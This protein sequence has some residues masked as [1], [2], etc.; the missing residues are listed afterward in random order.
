MHWKSQFGMLLWCVL[1]LGLVSSGQT[2]N[3]STD[4]LGSHDFGSGRGGVQGGNANACIYCHAP[5]N[6]SSTI[7]LWNQTLSTNQYTLNTNPTTATSVNTAS[8]LCLSCHDGSVAVG[9]TLS[10]GKIT[11]T[12]TVESIGGTQLESSHPFSV[13]PELQDDP[14]VVATLI[15]THQTK[16]PT[17]KLINNNI[18]C[19][20]CH[21][22]HNQYR[23][24]RLPEFLVRDNTSG[25]LCM[26]CH[27][28]GARTVNGRDNTL[29][30]W[31]ASSHATSSAQV[32]PKAGLGGYTTVAEFACSTCHVSH[33]GLTTT[34]LRTNPNRPAS[35]DDTAQACFTCHDGSDNLTQPILDVL[36]D[37]KKPGAI[38]HPFSDSNNPHAVNE[39]VVL[40][41]N[42]HATCSDCH[43]A[44][45][46]KATTQFT[47]TG[48]IRP[49]QTG[50][51]GVAAD[52]TV[53]KQ[54][55]YQY[56]S[57]L[58][59]HGTS[60]GKT[61]PL[62]FGYLPAR[63]F[64]SS[65]PLDVSLEFAHGSRSSHPVMR[66]ATN[67][68]RPSLLK[69]MWDINFKVPMRAISSRI[70]CTDCHNGD[71]NRE[72]GGTGPNGPHG[73][74]FVH[75]LERQ[76]VISQVSSGRGSLISNLNPTPILSGSVASPYALC[77]KCH[78]LAYINLGADWA[79]HNRH[80]QDGFS[81]SVCHS[82]HGVPLSTPGVPGTALVSFDM[83][84]V[85]E[86]GAPV[87]YNGGSS[88]TLTC[89]GHAHN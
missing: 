48:E 67:L 30:M 60:V 73:S 72:F 7:P 66:D 57:C 43:L 23:D 11:T 34:L 40:D 31:P 32:T 10:F 14:S 89:H 8:M 70:L 6:A 18:E 19:S 1:L 36:S 64:G 63:S 2:T 83:N 17:V 25:Q 13:Q 38:A 35:V 84:V 33:N 80:I 28:T 79:E 44:H 55:T 26:A 4:V 54:A 24:P 68:A 52:G 21:D 50:V 37:Y 76:Y 47:T 82:A 56:E 74:K 58:R 87:S 45:G 77:A 75:V 39:P 16:D 42:R 20:T 29:V 85:A 59:C 27:D 62:S 71:A 65:D 9:Q 22:V 88:C 61:A 5:H 12:G 81:C 49:S 53:L 15:S 51:A 46:A 69:N 86:N 3:L 41:R 78:D